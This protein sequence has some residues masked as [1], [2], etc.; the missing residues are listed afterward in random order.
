MIARTAD[1]TLQIFE[2]FA[3][4]LVPF[5][6]SEMARTLNMPISSCS[7]LMRTLQARGYLYEVGGR[8]AYYP[9]SRWLI[10]AKAI[11]DADPVAEFVQPYLQQLRDE[12]GET[13][14]LG[15]LLGDRLIHLAFAEGP[16]SIRYN[17]QAGDLLLIHTTASGKAIMGS[18]P[19]VQRHDF[20]ARLKLSRAT[21][22]TITGR[23]QLLAD[24][25]AGSEQG[26]WVARS[27]N[28][29]D[30]LAMAAPVS[31]AAEL[32]A[33]AIAGPT[34]R[35]EPRLEL[36]AKKLLAVCKKIGQAD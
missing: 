16:Q 25:T 5:T 7:N 21:P 13:T 36:M 29:P 32:Y 28:S 23:K 1:R 3:E 22:E 14:M 33:I 19:L 34:T 20:V 6:L 24:V 8:K 30:V 9:T 15:K 12:V 2:V 27:E 4:K 31:I 35:M 10:K 17:G 26:W 11:S 18:M